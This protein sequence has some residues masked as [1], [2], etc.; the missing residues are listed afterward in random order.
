LARAESG[1]HTLGRSL[2][3]EPADVFQDLSP[4]LILS[5]VFLKV[6]GWVLVYETPEKSL[7]ESWIVPYKVVILE[8]LLLLH[9]LE[10]ASDGAHVL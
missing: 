1:S 9:C 7:S 2:L 6:N 8:L 5:V 10:R 4:L 3:W